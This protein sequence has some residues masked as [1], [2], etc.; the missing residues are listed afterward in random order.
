MVRKY[1]AMLEQDL[2]KYDPNYDPAK[3]RKDLLLE[4]GQSRSDTSSSLSARSTPSFAGTVP[5]PV[6]PNDAEKTG[7]SPTQAQQKLAKTK[8]VPVSFGMVVDDGGD[9]SGDALTNTEIISS[10]RRTHQPAL[11]QIFPAAQIYFAFRFQRRR[12]F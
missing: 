9:D 4:A 12:R 5:S 2:M 6:P 7:T 11:S 8:S 10:K 1:A 3:A